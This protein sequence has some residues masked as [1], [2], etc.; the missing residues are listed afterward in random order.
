LGPTTQ[1]DVSNGAKSAKADSRQNRNVIDFEIPTAGQ[2]H[3]E[4]RHV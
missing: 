2:R 1:A 3:E 4:P